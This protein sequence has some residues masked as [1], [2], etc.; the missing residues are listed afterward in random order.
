MEL[1]RRLWMGVEGRADKGHMGH[2][3]G[4]NGMG[5]EGRKPQAQRLF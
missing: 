1:D 4:K 5:C 3:Y 2:E